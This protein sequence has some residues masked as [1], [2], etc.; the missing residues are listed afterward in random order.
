MYTYNTLRCGS[1]VTRQYQS[2]SISN[3][4]YYAYVNITRLVKT[5]ILTSAVVSILVRC[6]DKHGHKLR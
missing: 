6:Y 5:S 3:Y 4:K 2:L 1:S